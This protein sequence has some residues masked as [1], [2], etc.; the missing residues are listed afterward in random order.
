LQF[1]VNLATPGRF[2]MFDLA[3]QLNRLDVLNMLYTGYPRWKIKQLPHDKIKTFP[4]L[5]TPY[6]TSAR[7]GWQ[8]IR[9]RLEKAM[10]LSFDQWVASTITSAD[11]FHCLSGFGLNSHVILKEKFG[12][13]T[14]CDRGSC[15]ISFQK[16]I[17]EEEYA[18][19]HQHFYFDPWAIQR[20]I[21]EYN[22]CDYIVIPS[23]FAARSFIKYG[24][25]E[26]KIIK[27]PYG[28][29]LSLF[30]PVPKRDN[31][32]RILFVGNLSIEK[33]IPYLLEA[34]GNLKLPNLELW[35]IGGITP[36]IKPTL[37]KFSD[38]F[39]YLG[40]IP[41]WKL[42]EY[43]SQGSILVMPSLQEGMSLVQAQ[44]MACGLPVI[45]TENSGA[46]D[47]FTNGLE[48]IIIKARDS[49]AIRDAIILLYENPNLRE[50]M[51]QNAIRNVN[52]LGGWDTYGT[53]MKKSYEIILGKNS[54]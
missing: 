29:D 21:D 38:C 32:F 12:L 26:K 47:L 48:G 8:M 24:I 30:I 35:L 16:E 39:S 52:H 40:Y 28:V 17:L 4:W 22:F 20:E 1:K 25:D 11:I 19:F 14:I 51:S 2:H 6:M 44:A 9:K 53:K 34:F 5:M 46:E 43:Y 31:V 7:F 50:A 45:A 42:A 15:H 13:I 36:E 41:R 49:R 10:V 33:G 27:I 23:Y 54:S 3:E 37:N 18:K